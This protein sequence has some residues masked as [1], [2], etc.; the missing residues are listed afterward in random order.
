MPL[1]II[2]E[3][4]DKSGNVG[5]TSVN[6]DDGATLDGINGFAQ[7]WGQAINDLTLG[8]IRRIVGFISLVSISLTSNTMSDSADVEEIGKFQ[9]RSA[10]GQRVNISIPCLDETAVGAFTSDDL[11]LADGDVDAFLSALLDGVTISGH[12]FIACDVGEELLTT[13]TFAREA[14]RNSGKRGS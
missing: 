6:V 12:N 3:I 2:A 13:L 9:F 10:S 14:F 7:A 4:E 5:T 1:Q 8:V 11:N